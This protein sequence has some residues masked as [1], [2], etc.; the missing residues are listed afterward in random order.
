MLKVGDIGVRLQV[1]HTNTDPAR[2]PCCER[3]QKGANEAR[4]C[5]EV[6]IRMLFAGVLAAVHT[7]HFNSGK[8][9]FDRM[10]S[11]T[12]SLPADAEQPDH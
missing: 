12:A 2:I 3:V 8:S 5:L 9:R 1:A 6:Y 10:G 7:Q 11:Q 4:A